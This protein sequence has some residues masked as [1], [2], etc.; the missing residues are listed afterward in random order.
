MGIRY[1][2]SEIDSPENFEGDVGFFALDSRTEPENLPTG[3]LQL[4]QN[5]RLNRRIAVTRMGT[6]K[7]TN[8]IDPTGTVPLIVP[9][10]VGSSAIVRDTWADGLF[11]SCVFSD[12]NDDNKEWLFMAGGSEAFAWNEDDGVVLLSYPS[13]ESIVATDSVDMLQA[14]GSVYILR[15]EAAATV[16]VSYISRSGTTAT[17]V[18]TGGHGLTT[19]QYF[20]VSGAYP[21]WYNVSDKA[22]T[23]TN[24]TILTYTTGAPTNLA[25]RLLESTNLDIHRV[26]QTQSVPDTAHTLSCYCK[27]ISR[28]WCRLSFGGVDGETYG[29]YFDIA[30]GAVGTIINGA[31]TSIENAGGGWWRC[32]V[33]ATPGSGGSTGVVQVGPAIS[34]GVAAY[35]GDAAKGIYIFGAQLEA[36]SSA[37]NYEPTTSA[38][39]QRNLLTYSEDFTNAAWT[40]SECTIA[41]NN[42]EEPATGS[43]VF[44]QHKLPM[45]WDG[46]FSLGFVNVSH[47]TISA[48]YIYMPPSDYGLLQ[49]NRAILQYSRNEL[50]VSDILDVESYDSIFGVF[51]FTSGQADYLIGFHPYQDNK[52]LVMNRRSL[53]LINDIDGG[54]NVMTTQEITRQVG[55]VSRLSIVTCG[56][57]VLFL[58]DLGVFRLQPGLELQLRGNSEP[59]SAPIDDVV[60]TINTAAIQKAAGAY[61][62]NRYYL[63]IPVD[64]SPRNNRIV[65]FNFLNNAWESVDTLPNG[66]YADFL[67]VKQFNDTDTLFIISEEGGVYAYEQLEFDE[68]GPAGSAPSEF[69]IVGRLKTRRMLFGSYNLKHFNRITTNLS[70]TANS[71]CTIKVNTVNPDAT[72]TL[73]NV[74]TVAAED[75]TY[76]LIV[77]KRGYG[78][79]VEIVN[80]AGRTTLVNFSATAY[81]QNR[82]N[83]K[84][85]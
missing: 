12:P 37:S 8:D 7:V 34:D 64:D 61:W 71:S 74:S 28:D 47:G 84:I 79:D 85:T 67:E 59:L 41:G 57:D 20:S 81:E 29:G 18:V 6:D 58:S 15:G 14:E 73:K 66:M 72:K 1:D 39:G 52:T 70:F 35:T 32:I 68:F 78:M 76:P 21:N 10:T 69:V 23:V 77:N 55:C 24:G 53:Y 5:M 3:V 36:F 51:E 25:D 30:T 82:K 16:S 44:N 43:I 75:M 11:A 19:G 49:Q 33:T 80:T 60:R 83:V 54:V 40:A 27:S 42:T 65:V 63:A 62:N 13:G 26:Y 46:D 4:S 45:R 9:F 17:M 31:S 2:A 56:S 48:P 38:A 22:V 50:I